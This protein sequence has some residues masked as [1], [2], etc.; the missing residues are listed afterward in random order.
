MKRAVGLAVA[1]L[2]CSALPAQAGWIIHELHDGQLSTMYVQDNLVKHVEPTGAVSIIDLNKGL[3][4][5]LDPPRKVYWSGTPQAYQD[6]IKADMRRTMTQ[7][8][9]KVPADQQ[10]DTRKMM[11]QVLETHTMPPSD[12]SVEVKS[13]NQT[14]VIGGFK[15]QGYQVFADGNLRQELWIAG[16]LDFRQDLDWS[17]MAAIMREVN[18]GAQ[19]DYDPLNP[20][21]LELMKKGYPVRSIDH[22]GESSEITQVTKVEKKDLPKE[23]F[24]VPPGY[25]ALPL[26]EVLQ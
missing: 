8:L 15:A 4:Y 10:A 2:I 9:A 17:K 6:A 26:G 14:V 1:I 7:E 5:F 22:M 13:L 23:L 12:Q 11:E 19:A 16:K 24:Q 18:L 21:V 3:L 20:P 25:Q